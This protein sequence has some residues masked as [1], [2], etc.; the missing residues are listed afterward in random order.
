MEDQD[1][2]TAFDVFSCIVPHGKKAYSVPMEVMTP[3]LAAKLAA[4]PDAVYIAKCDAFGDGTL[5]TQFE[6]YLLRF[7]P[8]AIEAAGK[9]GT[10]G[11]VTWSTENFLVCFTPRVATFE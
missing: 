2:E 10:M 9:P 1:Y 3:K 8:L 6:R 7:G 4:I 11:S 5:N